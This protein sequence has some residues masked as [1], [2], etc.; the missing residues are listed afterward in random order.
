MNIEWDGVLMLVSLAAALGAILILQFL[1]SERNI[2]TWQAADAMR[3]G[4]AFAVFVGCVITAL[5]MFV[6]GIIVLF[7]QTIPRLLFT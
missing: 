7:V 1:R 4:V 6:M 5:S 2:K 3:R